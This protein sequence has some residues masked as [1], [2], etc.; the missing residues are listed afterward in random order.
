M[1]TGS[2][3]LVPTPALGV[4]QPGGAAVVAAGR[5]AG[6]GGGSDQSEPARQEVWHRTSTH[7][8]LGQKGGS[9]LTEIIQKVKYINLVKQILT[10]TQIMQVYYTQQPG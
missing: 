4:G 3:R 9:C 10:Y 1:L 8:E 6:G 7:P 2:H 5:G